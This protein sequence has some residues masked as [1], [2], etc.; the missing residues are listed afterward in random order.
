MT[1]KDFY[2]FSQYKS[3]DLGHNNVIHL[4]QNPVSFN[5]KVITIVIFLVSLIFCFLT[6]FTFLKLTI[7]FILPSFFFFT[8]KTL[9]A[10]KILSPYNISLWG[11]FKSMILKTVI[12]PEMNEYE[13]NIFQEYL[14]KNLIKK[15][16]LKKYNFI[17]MTNSK[18]YELMGAIIGFDEIQSCVNFRL[19]KESK[20]S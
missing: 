16:H 10:K 12:I 15:S 20:S 1:E 9:R 18:A 2:N 7:S 17:T 4:L 3:K 5:N 19:T 13:K 14:D 8:A 6:G 11:D